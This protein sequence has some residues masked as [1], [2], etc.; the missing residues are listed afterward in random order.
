MSEEQTIFDY[1]ILDKFKIKYK[2]E[3]NSIKDTI[4]NDNKHNE[5][6]D[7]LRIL[8]LI[9]FYQKVRYK[10]REKINYVLEKT[11]LDKFYY[12][13]INYLLLDAMNNIS[14]KDIESNEPIDIILDESNF[15]KLGEIGKAISSQTEKKYCEEII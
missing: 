12:E 5:I 11:F 15:N 2:D 14:I 4:L 6:Y 8:I 10:L 13:E 7:K 1:K 9:S 3:N